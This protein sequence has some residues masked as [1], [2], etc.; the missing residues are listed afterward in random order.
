[1]VVIDIVGASSTRRV[2]AVTEGAGG[3]TGVGGGSV[4][5]SMV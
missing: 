1:L 2:V 5:R 3:T 4:L